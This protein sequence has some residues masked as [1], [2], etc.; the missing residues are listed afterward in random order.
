MKLQSAICTIGNETV[1]IVIHFRLRMADNAAVD[2]FRIMGE[3]LD[4][5][6]DLADIISLMTSCKGA[7]DDP[8]EATAALL[9]FKGRHELHTPFVRELLAQGIRPL[10]VDRARKVM[11]IHD[12]LQLWSDMKGMPREMNWNNVMLSLRVWARGNAAVLTLSDME[13]HLYER[14]AMYP[15]HCT[16]LTAVQLAGWNTNVP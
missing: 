4:G 6:L 15:R 13:T 10:N 7:T 5:L 8:S 3:N 11:E 2:M 16:P 14:I 1:L 12:T 9:L